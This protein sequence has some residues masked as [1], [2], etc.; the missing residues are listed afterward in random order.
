MDNFKTAIE[1]MGLR[2]HDC[3]PELPRDKEFKGI[4]LGGGAISL[5]EA[6]F[7]KGVISVVKPD[8]VIELGTSLG[9]SA[10]AIGSVLKDFGKGEL[11]TVDFAKDAPPRALELDAKLELPIYWVSSD[12]LKFLETFEVD[13]KKRYLVFSDTDIPQRPEEVMRTIDKFP[14]GTFI[15]VHDTSDLHPFGPMHLK[16]TLLENG[17]SP[18]IIELPS[19][20]GISILKV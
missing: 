1:L 15:L 4:D 7:I 8:V 12:S 3:H 16:K 18:D 17:Y 5:E 14:E 19:P 2:R 20:R 11:I 13:E 6:H 10:I 9:A